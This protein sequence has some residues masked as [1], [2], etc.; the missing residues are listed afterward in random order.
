MV[1]YMPYRS[2]YLRSCPHEFSLV[3]WLLVRSLKS[4]A[5]GD[6]TV[7]VIVCL[8]LVHG[9][10]TLLGPPVVSA[11]TPGEA[12]SVEAEPQVQHSVQEL[13]ILQ[14][15]FTGIQGPWAWCPVW[16]S[17]RAVGQL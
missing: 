16:Y 11:A 2:N 15:M 14:A 17:M 8:A 13:G 7:I 6:Y 4:C 9:A 12:R 5:Q 3:C 10:A 1:S